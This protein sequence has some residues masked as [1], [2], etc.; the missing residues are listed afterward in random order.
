MVCVNWLTNF[1][2]R[3][4]RQKGCLF[5]QDVRSF[6][7]IDKHTIYLLSILMYLDKTFHETKNLETMYRVL[8]LVKDN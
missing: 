6:Y 7:Q 3:K 4:S 5:K 1:G 8:C 2:I